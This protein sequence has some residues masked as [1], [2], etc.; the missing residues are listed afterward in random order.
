MGK[1]VSK[2][3]RCYNR[4]CVR[5][6][7]EQIES[8]RAIIQE[9]DPLKCFR[10]FDHNLDGDLTSAEIY[11]GFK[12]M[13]FPISR[14]EVDKMMKSFDADGNGQIDKEEFILFMRVFMEA[15]QTAFFTLFKYF[16]IDEDGFITLQEFT[17]SLE[18]LG[19]TITEDEADSILQPYYN[20]D[21]LIDHIAFAKVMTTYL[22]KVITPKTRLKVMC[23]SVGIQKIACD[24]DS[25]KSTTVSLTGLT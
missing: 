10:V 24:E 21:K 1:V 25:A 16:D 23:E 3:T 17:I 7:K 5:C 19:K 2:C 22:N 14:A 4:C 11:A 13:D 9:G 15:N 12:H 8:E 6:R 18:K 20:K